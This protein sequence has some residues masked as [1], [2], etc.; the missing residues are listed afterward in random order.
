VNGIGDY[1]MKLG[2]SSLRLSLRP[3]LQAVSSI[4]DQDHIHG[5]MLTTCSAGKVLKYVF[6]AMSTKS[7][8]RVLFTCPERLIELR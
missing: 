1:G 7:R 4:A 5:L 3:L 2:R 6:V 8:Y